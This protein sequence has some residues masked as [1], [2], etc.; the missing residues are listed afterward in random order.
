VAPYRTDPAQPVS[1]LH[2]IACALGFAAWTVEY[3]KRLG[4]LKVVGRCRTCGRRWVIRDWD[5]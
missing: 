4:R 3:E 5:R 1:Q 2:R